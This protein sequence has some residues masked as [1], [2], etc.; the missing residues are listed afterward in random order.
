MKNINLSD[1]SKDAL[2]SETWQKIGET[3]REEII[4]EYLKAGYAD[5]SK[6]HDI[7]VSGTTY[8]VLK[9]GEITTFYN[10]F[11]NTLFDVENTRLEKEYAALFEKQEEAGKT[12]RDLPDRETEPESG[13]EENA[14]AEQSA[15]KQ[16]GSEKPA[17]CIK[18]KSESGFCGAAAYCTKGLE[19]CD[20]CY[21]PCNSRCGYL[22]KDEKNVEVRDNTAEKKDAVPPEKGNGTEV[23]KTSEPTQEKEPGKPS[24]Y[25]GAGGA[26]AKLK[27]EFEKTKQKDFAKPIIEYLI[28][29]CKE[30]ES[31]AEDI[32]QIHKTW[33]KCSDYIYGQAKEKLN[34]RFG[35]VGDDVVYEWAE[36][37]YH[38]D[39]KAEAE[40]KAKE[41]AERKK[42]PAGAAKRA[43]KAKERKKTPSS[44]GSKPEPAAEKSGQNPKTEKPKRNSRDMEGQMDIFSLMG[45]QGGSADE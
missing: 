37:Y 44:A 40:K 15:E 33:K 39:D 6:Q 12:G 11:G 1:K 29:R 4:K 7:K 19:C 13:Q 14:K 3:L 22:D 25:A 30:S 8:K 23:G 18:G 32:C 21:D 34:G 2:K 20:A 42:K 38:L 17:E 36:D 24:E 27:A 45:M 26:E 16:E 31:L 9:R 43:P 10:S 28:G 5:G 35:I 41:D